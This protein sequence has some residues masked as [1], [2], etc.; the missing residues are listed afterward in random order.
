MY[1]ILETSGLPL[2][3]AS[4]KEVNDWPYILQL[5]YILYDTSYNTVEMCNDYVK[6]DTSNVIINPD[7][8]NIHKISNSYLSEH[9]K[10]IN[11]VL[12]NFNIAVKKC[13]IIVGHNLSFDKKLIFVE[14]FR[15]KIKQE[16][17]KFYGSKRIRKN[18]Y[19]TMKKTTQF[20]N[21]TPA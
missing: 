5:A 2:K 4:I 10:N 14:C 19:C 1:S 8:Y 12:N 16:F 7:S 20:C 11:H 9:G 13:D 15:N 6:I 18:E 17:T 3:N 21:L